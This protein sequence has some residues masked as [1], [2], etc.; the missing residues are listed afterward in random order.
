MI[1]R[2]S[3]GPLGYRHSDKGA[4]VAD[5]DHEAEM[6]R[7]MDLIR[8]QR[9]ELFDA[10]LIDAE[11]FA[12]LVEDSESGQRV[13]RLEGYDKLR[14]ENAELKAQVERLSANA[15]QMAGNIIAV[16]AGGK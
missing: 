11:E 5:S 8:H 16:R 3:V 12:S 4:W 2:W 14:A 10:K 6:Q 1:Q 13:A 9:H 7:L 15:F